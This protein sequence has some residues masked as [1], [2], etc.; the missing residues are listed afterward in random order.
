[1]ERAL[2]EPYLEV[3]IRRI[4]SQ[5]VDVRMQALFTLRYIIDFKYKTRSMG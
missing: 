1:V 3:F 5:K 4:R 2:N